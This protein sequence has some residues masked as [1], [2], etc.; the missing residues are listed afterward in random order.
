M[1]NGDFTVT[2]LLRTM[3]EDRGYQYTSG[4][5]LPRSEGGGGQ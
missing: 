5:T 1:V 4:E 2:L 3:T